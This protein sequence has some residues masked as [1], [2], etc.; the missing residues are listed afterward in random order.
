MKYSTIK[1]NVAESAKVTGATKVYQ[2]R[3]AFPSGD[4]TW[5][6]TYAFAQD[7]DRLYLHT[8]QGWFNIAI[9]NT[10]PLWVTEPASSYELAADATAYNNGT[11]TE[12]IVRARD[13]EGMSL[14]WSY[15]ADT[16]M[17]NIANISQDSTGTDVNKYIIEPATQDSAGSATPAS[18]TLT[19]KVSDGINT[20]SKATTFTLTFDQSI[21]DTENTILFLRAA[22]NDKTNSAIDDK[23]DSNHTITGYKTSNSYGKPSQGTFTP[24]QN[25]AGWS[26]FF[27]GGH[28]GNTTA[29]NSN[30]N[31]HLPATGGT[32]VAAGKDR[33]SFTGDAN[34]EFD[35]DF[36]FEAWIWFFDDAQHDSKWRTIYSAGE[37][38]GFQV[39][40]ENGTRKILLYQNTASQGGEI[41]KS[42]TKVRDR[43][44]THVAISRSGTTI[45]L[46][47]DGREEATASKNHTFGRNGGTQYIG[48][49]DTDSGCWFGCICDLRIVKGSAVYTTDFAPPTTKLTNVTNTKLLTCDK[50][51]IVKA[52]QT[53][54]SYT[55]STNADNTNQDWVA[56][57]PWTPYK[58][59]APYSASKNGGSIYF[60]NAATNNGNAAPSYITI[61]DHADFDVGSNGA[62]CIEFWMYPNDT[63]SPHIIDFRGGSAS[64][65]VVECYGGG[66]L[67]VKAGGHTYLDSS[68]SGNDWTQPYQW[69]HIVLSHT[70]SVFKFFKNGVL[71]TTVNQ[72]MGASSSGGV[73]IG[74]QSDGN[75]SGGFGGFICDLRY[76]KG[77]AVH[78]G[79]SVT[80]PT[81][82]LTAITNTKLLL[83][84]T[85]FG[86]YDEGCRQNLVQFSENFKSDTGQYKFS[87]NG[88]SV[89]TAGSEGPS[90]DVQ[91]TNTGG[92]LWFLLGKKA[93]FETWF[94]IKSGA[95]NNNLWT[96]GGATAYSGYNAGWDGIYNIVY[97][98]GGYRYYEEGGSSN[99]YSDDT[100]MHN[101]FSWNNSGIY[102]NN[103]VNASNSP[104]LGTGIWNEWHDGN[105]P[106][107]GFNGTVGSANTN[108]I[109]AHNND[110]T[111][112]PGGTFY[113]ND[114]TTNGHLMTLMYGVDNWNLEDY[115]WYADS[116]Y[117]F[118]PKKETITPT[119]SWQLGRT[120]GGSGS[121]TKLIC[122]HHSTV[123]TDGSASNLTITAHNG[124]AAS[125]FAPIGG[126]KSVQLTGTNS[127]LKAASF[128]TITGDF[129]FEVW[130]YQTA[131]GAYASYLWGRSDNINNST[132]EATFLIEGQN[133]TTGRLGYNISQAG[134]VNNPFGNIFIELNTWYH[135]ALSRV[136]GV[137]YFFLDGTMI[138]SYTQAS[139]PTGN[140]TTMAIGNG[141]AWDASNRFGF[142]GYMSNF[143]AIIGSSAYHKSFTPKTSSWAG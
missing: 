96:C 44:W 56:C 80:I 16:A 77:S 11:A 125:S 74:R 52:A 92:I 41:V 111:G 81:E 71:C 105:P 70:G 4:T 14:T 126:M 85:D 137:Y 3:N 84:G 66:Q 61:S 142:T 38:N 138:G 110:Q 88:R 59:S 21:D 79:S 133:G 127:H 31:Y 94:R 27:G 78:T 1:L 8:G 82:P 93:T 28:T 91:G 45:K 63:E 50:P 36:T 98:N 109:P 108:H 2:N 104:A 123:T 17:N 60:D 128:P 47:I 102:I 134:H 19:F 62:W 54:G 48:S 129:S 51:Y 39:A 29:I 124:A 10:V 57:I 12:V 35:A 32:T 112:F 76:V 120:I 7:S 13:S 140:T 55:F 34:L 141:M 67:W 33:V 99:G 113:D 42:V 117:P 64:G 119:T 68:S 5:E 23:S 136:S 26:W 131:Q 20:L 25:P 101:S 9:I 103:N 15:T 75:N 90:Y 121:H 72:A 40:L 122:G 46:F 22:G 83:S 107:S 139:D 87:S 132:L 58:N 118:K 6:G 37:T 73:N 97:G 116:I 24:Y 30:I 106:S 65:I 43:Q 115:R 114:M 130:I 53:V 86:I 49:Y 18:G 95:G 135:L 89:D 100:W 143:R 69:H